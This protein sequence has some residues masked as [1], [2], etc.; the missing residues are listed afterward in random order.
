MRRMPDALALQ[1]P[2]ELNA[3]ARVTG[4]TLIGT[5][6]RG[7]SVRVITPVL[8][9]GVEAFEPDEVDVV[10][11]PSIRGAA[12]WWWR[13][14]QPELDV[15]A[16]RQR[17]R[18][19]WGGVGRGDKETEVTRASAVGVDVV[20]VKPGRVV[21]AGRHERGREGHL[22]ALPQWTFGEF[23]YALFP[24]Q[25]S[26]EERKAWTGSGDM[27]TRSWRVDLSFSLRVDWSPRGGAATQDED[28][29][30]VREAF[31]LWLHLGGYGARTR[32]GFGGLSVDASTMRWA[33]AKAVLKA[34]SLREPK[35]DRPTLGGCQLWEGRA[36]PR[37]EDAL[38]DLL[39]AFRDF[40]QG[41]S[42]GRNPG[43]DKAYGRSHWPEADSLRHLAI[44]RGVRFTRHRPSDSFRAPSAPRAMFGLP[45]GLNFIRA[46][47]E[48]SLASAELMPTVGSDRWASPLL[49]RVVCDGEKYIPVALSLLGHRP[50]AVRVGKTGPSIPVRCN[51]PE[52]RGG[53]HEPVRGALQDAQGDA[54]LAFTRWLGRDRGYAC[55]VGSP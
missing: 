26:D 20:V 27:P 49:L 45:I 41:T 3:S 12:R 1:D 34:V 38:R 31:L 37:A 13:A 10:R 22:R 28:S 9:G 25:R 40:R 36:F 29:E 2:S 44:E 50:D 51:T 32:R 43:R 47:R 7:V 4:R 6:E 14:L 18:E 35:A 53:A 8:G 48:D 23:G 17:E 42:F 11:I 16:L 55:V 46:D 15:N 24:L 5:A 19:V 33:D 54:V 30:R 52:L 39:R 21:P